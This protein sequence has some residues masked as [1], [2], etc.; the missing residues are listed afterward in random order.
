MVTPIVLA[1]TIFTA[2]STAFLVTPKTEAQI[3][4]RNSGFIAAACCTKSFSTFPLKESSFSGHHT[5]NAKDVRFQHGVL[6]IREIMT[7]KTRGYIELEELIMVDIIQRLGLED[8]FREEMH[9]ALEKLRVKSGT[10]KDGDGKFYEVALCFRLLRQNGYHV[11]AD[12]F[13]KF[14]D[15]DGKFKHELYKDV[16]ALLSLFE[17]SQLSTTGEDILGEA[18]DFSRQ[19]L[20]DALK[21]IVSEQPKAR[22]IVNTLRFPYHKNL[23]RLLAKNFLLDFDVSL[24]ILHDLSTVKE[25]MNEV[26]ELALIDFEMAQMTYKNE[27]EEI[28]KW[29]KTLNLD[30]LTFAR[31]EPF[32][33]CMWSFGIFPGPSM[34][35]ERLELAK[36]VSFAYIIDDIFD[37]CGRYDE[38]YLFTKAINRWEYADIK[39]LPNNYMKVCFKA[40]LET[41]DDFS[42][43]IQTKHGWNP[44]ELLRNLWAEHCNACL[45]ESKW[46]V[47]RYSPT[48]D[49]Y[50]N[51]GIVTSGTHVVLAHAFFLIGQGINKRSLEELKTLPSIISS[52]A[53]ILRLW[54]DAGIHT[55]KTPNGYDGSYVDIFMKEQKCSSS[56]C[57]RRHVR[58]MISDAWKCLN[59][60][61]V[62]PISPFSKDFKVACVNLTRVVPFMY[63]G[64]LG[65]V[66]DISIFSRS[67]D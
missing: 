64:H 13:Y 4:I 47:A 63:T 9:V 44:L 55:D 36:A 3:K 20:E 17:S 45:L 7:S 62:S 59:E 66:M 41:T 19:Y 16:K 34:S 18:C 61:Y 32:K 23:A 52:A 50:L 30:N 42:Y 58:Q 37:S 51:N 43:K 39:G 24:K 60:E 2:Q 49:E 53:T 67:L 28:S 11:P 54:N 48:A 26:Q 40:L 29:G 35:E 21:D 57:A 14:K 5:P 12:V 25:W 56:D 15:N 1:T 31:I 10:L 8:Y 33:W 27:V 22:I 6:K 46:S 65:G 38:L